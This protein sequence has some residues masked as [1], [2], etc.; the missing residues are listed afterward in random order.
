[1]DRRSFESNHVAV[2]Q[3]TYMVA[4]AQLIVNFIQAV[5]AVSSFRREEMI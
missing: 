5:S 2:F 4:G 3:S 1:M